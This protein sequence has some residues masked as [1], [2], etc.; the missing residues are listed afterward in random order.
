VSPFLSVSVGPHVA[1]CDTEIVVGDEDASLT[2]LSVAAP[3]RRIPVVNN[4]DT[5]QA[6]VSG[7]LISSLA[8]GPLHLTTVPL[9]CRG[10]LA[11]THA[12]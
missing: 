1:F 12:S 4:G 9:L 7:F 5:S 6:T 10:S 2:P 3:S 11:R 8:R